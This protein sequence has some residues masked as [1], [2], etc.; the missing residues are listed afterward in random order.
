MIKKSSDLK[1]LNLKENQFFLFYGKNEG[2]KNQIVEE[3]FKINYS[4]I[5]MKKAK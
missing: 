5:I 4:D 3:I 1:T 2:L